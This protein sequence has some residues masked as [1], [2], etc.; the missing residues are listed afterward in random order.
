MLKSVMT[1]ESLANTLDADFAM[2]EQLRPYARRLSL[3]QLDPRRL[4]RLT[5]GALR[6][7]GELAVMLPEELNTLLGRLKGGQFQIR[8]QHE[9]LESLI[10]TLDKVSNRISFALIMAGH[11]SSAPACW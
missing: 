8:V 6:E 10:Q 1:I 7:A 3:E 9:H 4:L 5:R 2:L 11:W